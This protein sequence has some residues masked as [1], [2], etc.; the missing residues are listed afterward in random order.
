MK[1]IMK[2][3]YNPTDKELDLAW[4]SENTL[5]IF[6]TNTLLNLYGYAEKTRDDFFSVVEKIQDRIWIPYHVALEYQRRRID[7]IKEEK[8]VFEKIKNNINKI[9]SVFS[10]DFTQLELEK[11]I[12]AL[13]ESTV[14]LKTEIK[15]LIDQ[16][17]KNVDKL[18]RRQLNVNGVDSIRNRLDL[19]F[20]GKVGDK[21]EGQK[22][23]D[24]I[25]NEGVGRY[26]KK[27]PPGYKDSSKKQGDDSEFM[28]AGLRYERQ[29][30]DLIIW[31]Q[32]LDYVCK[33]TIKS[34]IFI[35]D[36][37]KEDWWQIEQSSGEKIIGPRTELAEEIKSNA[38]ID[39]FMMYKT[40]DFL[41]AASKA[42]EVKIDKESV[43]DANN[44]FESARSDRE[45]IQESLNYA[46][47]NDMRSKYAKMKKSDA[48]IRA[49]AELDHLLDA[50]KIIKKLGLQSDF[51]DQNLIKNRM[52]EEYNIAPSKMDKFL[53][54]GNFSKKYEKSR[55]TIES[56]IE[57]LKNSEKD[58]IRQHFIDAMTDRKN[59][60][61]SMDSFLKSSAIEEIEKR[62]RD[63]EQAIKMIP[64]ANIG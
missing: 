40:S 59:I 37:S 27:I 24:D 58:R 62:D 43:E 32:M 33:E 17:Q 11:R 9:E 3:F 44:M 46:N 5:F 50:K 14:T 49:N 45:K 60:D 16:Y 29:F 34:V 21:P 53:K 63:I 15:K 7:V 8:N 57:D 31:R 26:S 18:N 38:L 64:S 25:Y 19:F 47:F 54:Q 51:S 23:L 42:L 35:T 41:T 1:N 20:D 36:D 12:P 10:K 56:Y 22:W 13:A 55:D 52:L 28:H 48:F 2:G 39:L 61:G 30:G 6:D 4:N